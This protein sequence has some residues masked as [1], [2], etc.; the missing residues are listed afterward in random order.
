[1]LRSRIIPL[2]LLQGGGLV[3]TR[4]FGEPRYVGDP[5]NAVKIFNEKEVDELVIYDI[6]ASAEGRAPDFELLHSIAVASRMPLTYGGGVRRAE[7]AMRLIQSG[8]EKVSV[9]SGAIHRPQ[10]IAEMASA[11]GSQSVVV[12]IDVKRSGFRRKPQVVIRNGCE[13]APVELFDFCRRAEDLGAGEIVVNDVD[14]DGTMEGYDLALAR[15]VRSV[16]SIPLSWAGGAGSVGDLESLISA[17]GTVGAAAGSIFLFHGPYRA[18]LLSYTR[19]K[20]LVQ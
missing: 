5:M 19:P 2:L 1:M 6:D 15:Q 20:G 3:K 7:D 12:T 8:F 13:K 17:V 9:S 4:R 16:I 11:V 14:R 18:V 10:L